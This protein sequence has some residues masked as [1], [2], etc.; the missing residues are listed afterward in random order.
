MD[1]LSNSFLKE[2]SRHSTLEVLDRESRH[3]SC[4]LFPGWPDKPQSGSRPTWDLRSFSW[5]LE[6]E[7]DEATEDLKLD[8]HLTPLEDSFVPGASH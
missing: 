7:Q 5:R 8:S 3:V 4:S 6:G 2:H 1:L